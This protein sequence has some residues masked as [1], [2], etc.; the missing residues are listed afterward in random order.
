MEWLFGLAVLPLLMCGAMCLGG[1]AAAV[2]GV[3]RRRRPCDHTVVRTDQRD[4]T[5]P[6]QIA[7]R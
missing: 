5:A 3:R 2:L 7:P 4:E 6:G 1:V